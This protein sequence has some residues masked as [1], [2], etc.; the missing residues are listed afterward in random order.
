MKKGA[1]WTEKELQQFQQR[2][3]SIPAK[4]DQDAP[5]NRNKYGNIPKEVDGI[6]FQ[7][8]KEAEYYGK[9][10]ILQRAGQIDKF[11]RQVAYKLT[12]NGVLICKYIADFVVWWPGG[13]VEVIDVKGEATARLPLFKIK[14]NLMKACHGIVIKIV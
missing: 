3:S 12:V 4:A 11:K 13:K 9:L 5:V 2:T 6:W 7:S 10:K 8:T 1:R 14:S